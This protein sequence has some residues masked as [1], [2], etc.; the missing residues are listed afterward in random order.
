MGAFN[1]GDDLFQ[2]FSLGFLV[3]LVFLV[4][5]VFRSIKQRTIQ[6]NRVEE[7]VEKLSEE[8]KRGNS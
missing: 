6:M 8:V 4:A 1:L 3:L 5:F 2:L 7:N